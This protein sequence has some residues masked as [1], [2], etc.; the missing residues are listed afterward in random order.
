MAAWG[1]K[2]G[3]GEKKKST[4]QPTVFAFADTIAHIA[5]SSLPTKFSPPL[6]RL[7]D[8]RAQCWLPLSFP[9]ELGDGAMTAGNRD[10][11]NRLQQ[12]STG[13][14]TRPRIG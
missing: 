2:G 8:E 14:A 10:I 6:P 9:G 7:T 4:R 3:K 12:G 5:F 13:H 11:S 1:R